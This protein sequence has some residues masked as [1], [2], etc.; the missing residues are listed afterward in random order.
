MD[1][2]IL[3]LFLKNHIPCTSMAHWQVGKISL[4]HNFIVKKSTHEIESPHEQ[5]PKQK[6]KPFH[7]TIPSII[8]IIIH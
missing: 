7:S 4:L 3:F 1:K 2:C 6:E 5:K 8:I